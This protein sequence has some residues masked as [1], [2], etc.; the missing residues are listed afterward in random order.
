MRYFRKGVEESR[1]LQELLALHKLQQR[2]VLHSWTT[3]GPARSSFVLMTPRCPCQSVWT[4]KDAYLTWILR[5]SPHLRGIMS[6]RKISEHACLY[7]PMQSWPNSKWNASRIANRSFS[8]RDCGWTS[9][10]TSQGF[11]ASAS[12]WQIAKENEK[13]RRALIIF[14][15]FCSKQNRRAV[16]SGSLADATKF[17]C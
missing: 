11:P 3:H 15:L 9:R 4:S 17:G 1:P 12:S 16:F 13:M 5:I 2:E 7:D 14:S 10:T 6:M 8:S